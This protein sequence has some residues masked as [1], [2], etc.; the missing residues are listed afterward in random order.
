MQHIWMSAAPL[1][2]VKYWQKRKQLCLNLHNQLR[3]EHIQEATKAFLARSS[4]RSLVRSFT[5]LVEASEKVNV[6]QR[7]T[8]AFVRE[9]SL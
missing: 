7:P 6:R 8:C 4:D 5:A 9:L 2:E 3:Q 1:E